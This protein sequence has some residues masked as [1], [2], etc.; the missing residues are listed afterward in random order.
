[1]PIA[2]PR[3]AAGR[4]SPRSGLPL[5]AAAGVLWGTGGLLGRLLDDIADLGPAAVAT[6]RLGL[7]GALIC[8]VLLGTRR[9]WPRGRAAW[10]RVAATGVLAATF[11]GCFFGAVALTSV[12]LATLVTIGSAPVV[13]LTVEWCTRRRGADR[14]TVA[15]VV[16]ALVGLG[17]LVGVPADG[18]GAGAVAAGA[19]L[20]VLAGSGFAAITLLAARPVP[21][22]DDLTTTGCAFV[23]GGA[24]L[25]PLAVGTSG[26]AFRPDPASVGLLVALAT[27][28]TALAYTLYFRGAAPQ[29][30]GRGCGDGVAGAADRC[31]PGRAGA[32]RA[33]RRP[34]CGRRG[35]ARRDGADHRDGPGEAGA[36]DR[37]ER[38]EPAD[39][40]DGYP[41]EAS[42]LPGGRLLFR[43]STDGL[44]FRILVYRCGVEVELAGEFGW[45]D[46]R[47][48]PHHLPFQDWGRPGTGLL[49][50]E[51]PGWAGYPLDVPGHW[52]PGV[53]VAVFVEGDGGGVRAPVAAVPDARHS[54]ALFVVRPAT[55]AAS[56]LYKLP[57]FTYHAYNQVAPDPGDPVRSW[58][59]YTV[60]EPGEL[61]APVPASVSLRRPG[62]GIGGTPW[63]VFNFDPFDA[64]PRQTFVHW[65][66]PFVGWLEVSGYRVD[67]CTDLDLHRDPG[68][69][70]R[71]RVLVSAGHDEY[72]TD[73][74][75]D[76]TERFVRAG[77][78]VAFF[79]G[80]TCWW[81][82]VLD[83]DGV[84]FRRVANWSDVPGPDRPENL[85]TGVSFRNGGERDRDDHP[86]PVGYRVQHADHW[87]YAGTGLRDGDVFGDRPGEYLVGYEC[88]GAHF[89]RGGLGRGPVRP[90]GNDGTP[91]GFTILGVG[92]AAASGWG[93]GNKA[94]TMGLHRPGGTV[95]T[96]ATTDWPRVL[97]GGTCP[98]V[99]RV[100]RNVLDR[101][102]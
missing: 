59:L 45:F 47:A 73:R 70:D 83:D 86:V 30:R 90:S 96:A 50:E 82:V 94:A 89:D 37:P 10:R 71:Y 34:G 7:G 91:D 66:A 16:L 80:N 98:P 11:Q 17:L 102:G 92:D 99:E 62:G 97:V 68:L 46:G 36:V 25:L 24:L 58:C 39:M 23:L 28:P 2:Q 29:R 6:Y 64:T 9:R 5:L 40:I 19:T 75:R 27:V 95:F 60:P 57:L 26:L 51:L 52:R 55:P 14:R 49:G 33:A 22:L 15:A 12:S 87:V 93:H 41:E 42:V 77:G 18:P 3:T 67:Y 8:A 69:L 54:R 76:G 61:P 84:G 78:N 20:A 48:S 63:D 81:R 85:L 101:L 4:S 88:D 74:M 38:R 31:G 32:R 1:M 13:V 53:H 43:V 72:W 100:T 79:G 65:D 44:A 56:I 21:G 35:A